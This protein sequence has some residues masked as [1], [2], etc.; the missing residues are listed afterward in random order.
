MIDKK[1]SYHRRGGWDHDFP[2]SIS[3]LGARSL[4]YDQESG[5]RFGVEV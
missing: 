3:Q 2:F 5:R 4:E 1:Y